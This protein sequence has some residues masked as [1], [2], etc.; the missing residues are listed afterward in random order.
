[1][2]WDVLRYEIQ[3]QKD[4]T[5]KTM[6]AFLMQSVEKLHIQKVS[7][8][9]KCNKAETARLLDIGVAIIYRKLDKYNIQ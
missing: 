6:S 4:K 2:T 9:T 1:M 8:Y 7:N 5:N 3:H